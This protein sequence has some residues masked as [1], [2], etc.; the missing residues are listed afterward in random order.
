[1]APVHRLFEGT[2]GRMQLAATGAM[3]TVVI[4]SVFASAASGEP[5]RGVVRPVNQASLSTDIP[6]RL[7]RLP[8]REGNAFRAGDIIAA[9]DCRRVEAEQQAARGMLREAELNLDS[10]VKLDSYKAVGRNEL[11]IARARLEKAKGEHRMIEAR[12]E[13]CNV[14]APFSGR[15]ADAPVRVWEFTAAQRPYLVIVEDG[16]LEIDFIVSSRLWVSLRIGQEIDFTIDEIPG[17]HGT[18]QIT[19]VNPTVDPV[20]KTLRIVTRVL[21]AP[22]ALAIG[23]S[24]AGALLV[25]R[26]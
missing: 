4:A 16:T 18:A 8:F 10:N 22:D 14:R 26:R 25:A 20:S 11:E 5:M 17:G 6:M 15:V 19:A 13:D 24:C 12:H 21:S 3:I 23:M 9:F 2:T 7:V 1:M